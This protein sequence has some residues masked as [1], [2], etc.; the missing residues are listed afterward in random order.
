MYFGQKIVPVF[1]EE[2]EN[3][4][5]NFKNQDFKEFAGMIQDCFGE[6]LEGFSE[7]FCFFSKDKDG[8]TGQIFFDRMKDDEKKKSKGIKNLEEIL[9][10][11]FGSENK[12]WYVS[13]HSYVY[14]PMRRQNKY[15]FGL[16]N[17]VVD[18]DFHK[19]G[20]S[21]RE[22]YGIIIPKIDALI[23]RVEA[24][25]DIPTPN[26]AIFT[27]RGVQLVY[28][29]PSVSRKIDFLWE[30]VANAL[31]TRIGKAGE[32]LGF[33]LDRSA[34]SSLS[35]MIR[36]PGTF[37][38]AAGLYT[39]AAVISEEKYTFDGLRE[40]LG[41]IDPQKEAERKSRFGEK[42][43]KQKE[44]KAQTAIIAFGEL[45]K[46]KGKNPEEE[47]EEDLCAGMWGKT[48]RTLEEKDRKLLVARMSLIEEILVEGEP[49]SRE[50]FLFMWHNVAM[51]VMPKD[52]GR[53]V[54][55]LNA[56]LP[57]PLPEREI[58]DAVNTNLKKLAENGYGYRY[59]DKTFIEKLQL[60][61]AE[62]ERY[63]ELKGCKKVD[64]NRARDTR[65]KAAKK[66]RNEM[67]KRFYA[68]GRFGNLKKQ[69]KL[70]AKEIA[71]R[72]G[73]SEA[74]VRRVTALNK[75][76]WEDAERRKEILAAELPPDLPH[77]LF[78]LSILEHD[79]REAVI[80]EMKEIRKTGVMTEKYKEAQANLRKISGAW[81]LLR[82]K[83][84]KPAG[85]AF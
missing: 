40:F 85:I 78:E 3:E 72:T 6:K 21:P 35:S 27:G 84:G 29:F 50:V 56:L 4:I 10:S 75:K 43:Q 65:R 71:K 66:Q 1:D 22:M 53:A 77:D 33:T 52:A 36:I 73:A 83:L 51:R 34:S 5:R 61:Q 39:R 17:F 15:L 25:E 20:L 62:I 41:L 58:K 32:S 74:T 57:D 60:S 28:H 11:V 13:K 76:R 80:K 68:Q 67:V 44:E 19:K 8:E 18:L 46:L 70:S 54:Y 45:D 14:G 37:N 82:A 59:K 26:L 30:K 55:E 24:A 7:S 31:A 23:D 12:D 42:E 16:K 2:T 48:G 47:I 9:T 79:A 64:K 81:E 38:R 69:K 63:K 49:F